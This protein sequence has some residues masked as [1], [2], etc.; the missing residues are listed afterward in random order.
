M[1]AAALLAVLISPYEKDEFR[2][3]GTGYRPVSF[4]TTVLLRHV[5]SWHQ[6]I[7]CF[8]SCYRTVLRSVG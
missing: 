6:V 1:R 5:D 8:V 3:I 4:L 2:K 7:F